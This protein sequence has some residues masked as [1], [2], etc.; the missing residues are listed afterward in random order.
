MPGPAPTSPLR[1]VVAGG[2]VAG[3][4]TAFALRHL[5]PGLVDV[6][7]VAPEDEFTYRPMAVREPFSYAAA[8]HHPLAGIAAAAG[9]ELLADTFAWVDPA[10]RVAHTTLGAALPYDALVLALGTHRLAAFPHATT[11]DDRAMDESLHGIVQDMEQGYLHRLAFAMP[12]GAAW[13][14]P[15][16]ELALMTA[17]RA[18]AMC[19]DVDV[20][21]VTPE[22]APLDAFGTEASGAVAALLGAR[23]ISVECNAVASV[24]DGRHVVLGPDRRTLEVDRVVALP[25][26]RGPGVRGLPAAEHGFVEVDDHCRVPGV[27]GI[28]AAGD[29]TTFPIKH[30]GLASQQAD[31]AARGIARHAGADVEAGPL[32]PVINGLL[33]TGREPLYLSATVVAGSGFRSKASTEPLWS[34]P[35]KIAALHLAPY[36]EELER[37]TA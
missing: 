19:V 26:L 23:G 27:E 17:E 12:P 32:R 29:A 10:A 5:A 24:P 3:L 36:L 33:L 9:A 8:R 31:V 1:V 28:Y 15:L 16:Y 21:I 14:L 37:T 11:V 35:T 22:R 13:P 18:N 25:E 7:I 2:G 34:P 20:T 6:T 30:G 4:E